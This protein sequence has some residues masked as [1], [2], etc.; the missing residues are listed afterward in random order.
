MTKEDYLERH[1]PHRIVLLYTFKN[2][3]E[4][5]TDTAIEKSGQGDFYR[6]SKDISLLMCRFLFQE[7]GIGFKEHKKNRTDDISL[8]NFNYNISHLQIKKLNVDEL[9]NHIHY[10]KITTVLIAANRAVAHINIDYVDHDL[11][12][13]EKTINVLIP[14]IDFLI[15]KI[16]NNIYLLNNYSETEFWKLLPNINLNLNSTSTMIN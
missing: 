3:F 16:I 9:K 5:Q 12:S 13:H 2:R 15:D 8:H 14:V 6:C 10:N 11:T 1:L 7:L 4:N